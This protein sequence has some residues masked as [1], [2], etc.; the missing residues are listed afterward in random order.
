MRRAPAS[1]RSRSAAFS[2]ASWSRS[3]LTPTSCPAW[4]CY[5]ASA[6][7]ALIASWAVRSSL[8]ATASALSFLGLGQT[9][10]QLRPLGQHRGEFFPR[11]ACVVDA[12]RKLVAQLAQLLLGAG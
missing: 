10:R 6:L 8:A 12:C 3:A 5:A 4:P 9:P 2:W 11:R 7:R 1:A